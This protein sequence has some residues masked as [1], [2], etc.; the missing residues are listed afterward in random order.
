MIAD[1]CT[2]DPLQAILGSPPLDDQPPRGVVEVHEDDFQDVCDEE[3]ALW[4]PLTFDRSIRNCSPC[5]LRL[6]TPRGLIA[7]DRVT[8]RTV[9]RE[10]R[11]TAKVVEL[12]RIHHRAEC[13]LTMFERAL[14][15]GD[16]R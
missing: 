2:L 7:L 11:I 12:A 3:F 13:H 8:R 9:K 1:S 14:D 5:D 16:P 6:S 15:P 4:S 10:S